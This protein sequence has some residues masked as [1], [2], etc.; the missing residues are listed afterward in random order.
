MGCL[1]HKNRQG[2][3]KVEFSCPECGQLPPEISNINIDNKNIEFKCKIC[4]EEE[5]NFHYFSKE[6]QNGNGN[7]I[8]YY[9]KPQKGNQ[10][11]KIWFKE[12]Q[13][14]QGILEDNK[15][16]L[17]K[18]FSSEEEFNKA[19]EKIRENNEKL[20]KIIQLNKKIK[21]G[22]QIYQNNYFYVKSLNNICLSYE[23][24]K[25]RDSKDTKFL[26]TA[27]DDEIKIFKKEIDDFFDEKDIKIG[28]QEVSL[29]L[30]GIKLNDKNI[31][32]ISLIKFNQLKDINLSENEITNIE[33]LCYANL[34]FLEFLNLSSNKIEKI[35]PLEE[36]NS[37]SLKYLFIQDNQI[38]DINVLLNPYFQTLEILRLE[39]N[40]INENSDSF[41]E[42][43]KLY[44]KNTKILISK[45][46]EIDEI[47]TSYKINGENLKN[48]EVEGT[49]EGDLLLK[50]LFIVITSK[51]KIRKL[52][53]PNNGI[54]EPSIL[55]RILFNSL[56]EL[57]LSSNNIKNL[58]FLRQMKAKE[59]ERLYLNNNKINDLS[60]LYNIKEYFPRLNEITLKANSFDPE[61]SKFEKLIVYLDSK[62]AKLI[63]K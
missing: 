28:R 61:E 63:I 18:I 58:Y 24:E 56:Q 30:N 47:Q 37:K 22:S 35:E 38:E 51:N 62:K 60:L 54:E 59:L 13:N 5:Y 57:D 44:N 14:T 4:A 27:L 48:I 31:K 49:N 53:L 45:T 9:C 12:Y 55:N 33:S 23:K 19:K 52:K 25:S 39:K 46:T 50:K 10:E 2:Y 41:K 42:L 8:N 34:P 20:K 40:K 29:I 3:V 6:P 21:E 32:C 43:L 11:N 26:F 7:I 1:D 16:L 36:I 15:S 17:Q